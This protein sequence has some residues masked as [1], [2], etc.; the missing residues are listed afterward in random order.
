[1]RKSQL[2]IIHYYLSSPPFSTTGCCFSCASFAI[3]FTAFGS[4]STGFTTCCLPEFPFPPL[5]LVK[6][7]LKASSICSIDFKDSSNSGSVITFSSSGQS[8]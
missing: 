1:M 7:F 8:I 2:F 5:L 4:I 3:A 6:D